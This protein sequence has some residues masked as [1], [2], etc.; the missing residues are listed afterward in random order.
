[1]AERYRIVGLLGRGGMGEVYRADD[2]KLGQPVALKFL[3]EQLADDQGR[4]ERF[5]NEVRIARQISHPNVCRV[6]DIGEVEGFHYLSMEYVDGED[7][8]SLLR[9]IG[10]LPGDKA[11]EIARQLCAGLA[12]AHDKGVLHRDLKPGNVMI[13]GRGKV[14]ITDFGLAAL[15]GAVQGAEIR[16]GTPAYM[17]PEQLA[18]RE[19]TVRSDVYAL[20]LVLYETLTGKTAFIAN[21]LA[22]LVKMHESQA[23]KN[24]S[25]IVPDLDPAVE[26]VILRC[27]EKDPLDRPG[28]ALA[29]AAA[30]PGG[31][32]LAAALAAGETPS[33]EMVAAAGD[34]GALKP[35]VAIAC[36]A[37]IVAAFVAGG[38]MARSTTLVGRV[39]PA[40][41]ADVLIE[42]SHEVIHRLGYTDAAPYSIAAFGTDGD[43]L[44]WIKKNDSSPGRWENLS[45]ERPA[46]IVFWYRESPRALRPL[47]AQGKIQY[48]D[49]PMRISG[50]K[51]V[52]LDTLGRLVAFDAVPPQVE[53]EP[54]PSD[55]PAAPDWSPLFAQ[56]ELDLAAFTSVAPKWTPPAYADARAAWEG[57]MPDRPGSKI[58]VEAASYRGRPVY[59]EIV[60]DWS[61]PERMQAAEQRRGAQIGLALN[62]I[63]VLAL[64]VVAAFLARRNVRAGR[65]DR[66][67]AFR[68]AM[69]MLAAGTV[70]AMLEAN[71]T[72]VPAQEWNTFIISTGVALFIAGMIWLLYLALEPMVRRRWPDSIISWSRVLSGRWR[73]PLVGRDLLAGMTLG[74]VAFFVFRVSKIA[75]ALMGAAPPQ[76]SIGDLDSLLG[77][78]GA[79]TLILGTMISSILSPMV[80]LFVFTLGR[81]PARDRWS[82]PL[83]FWSITTLLTTLARGDGNLLVDFVTSAFVAAMITWALMRF[84]LLTA[85]AMQFVANYG[86]PMT[87][88]P[89]VFYSGAAFLG[90]AVILGLAG[91]AFYVS[92][93]GQRLAGL[94]AD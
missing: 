68:V 72:G 22:E 60:G 48:G 93:G 30:L 37:A 74:A 19:V 65:G 10:R 80:L 77:I 8:A 78:R 85:M 73:D 35:A 28:S 38:A 31:D 69:F 1:V 94:P 9:R 20:G 52:Q 24:P 21:T 13:D 18:G 87:L 51:G 61:R 58:R 62:L 88:D 36:L 50:M 75:P 14:R 45:K 49:P 76:P 83:I 40:K 66:R 81:L 41:S 91:W 90:L 79:V 25:T 53:S 43:Y 56:A 3:P 29:V 57:E 70:G 11:I 55:P 64:L 23:V 59:F 54:A 92:L 67:G 27:L 63:I 47:N 26:R 32:P 89:S 46:A 42:K 4:L 39:Q 12:A 84:G 16:V 82:P 6:Y 2:M 17:A 5:F 71:H 7:L 34:V 44:E 86:I 33:P 15:A